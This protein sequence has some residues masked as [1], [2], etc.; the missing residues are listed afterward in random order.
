MFK[1]LFALLALFLLIAV[2]VTV[3]ELSRSQ[4]AS[5]TIT[6]VSPPASAGE[7]NTG[8]IETVVNQVRVQKG[9]GALADDVQLTASAMARAEFLCDHDVWSHDGWTGSLTYTYHKAGENIAYGDQYQTPRTIVTAWVNSPTHYAN[10]T[11]TAFT[12]Q[13]MG[14][15]FCKQYQGHLNQ[16]IIVNHFR[17]P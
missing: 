4:P 16:V 10:M 2:P 3:K 5:P 12:Q 11:D 9:L 8:D 14:I 1:R 13:G 6:L 15:K 7:I 17:E